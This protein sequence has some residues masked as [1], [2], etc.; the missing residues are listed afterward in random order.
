MSTPK[1][2]EMYMEQGDGCC[3]SHDYAIDGGPFEQDGVFVTQAVWC[4]ACG[5]E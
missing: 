2:T 3:T 4:T 5:T 1:Q